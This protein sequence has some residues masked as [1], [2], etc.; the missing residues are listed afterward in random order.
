MNSGLLSTLLYIPS[1]LP[2]D[3]YTKD[4]K[5][6][7][8]LYSNG[9]LIMDKCEDLLPDTYGFV[10]GLVDSPDLSVNIS[11]EMLQHDRQLK[12]I[13][14]NLDKKIKSELL[15]MLHKDRENYEKFF[16]TF[17]TTLKFGLVNYNGEYYLKT[18]GIDVSIYKVVKA[19][20]QFTLNS[21]GVDLDYST[22]PSVEMMKYSS[23]DLV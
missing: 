23:L 1:H 9:V 12:I 15:D 3:Y 14:K 20:G 6:G 19:E 5:R 16:E 4:F 10:R 11:R 7:L 13:A 21:Y 2:Y 18:L 22:M 17:G 8:Q